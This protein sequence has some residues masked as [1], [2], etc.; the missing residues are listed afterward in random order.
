MSDTTTDTTKRIIKKYPNRRLYDTKTSSYVTLAYIK[1]LV[2]EAQDFRV[3][4]TK[5][6]ED[7]TRNVLLQIIL[8]EESVGIPIF[9]E[10]MLANIIRFYGQTMQSGMG[11][12]LERVIQTMI[13]VQNQIL[14]QPSLSQSPWAQWPNQ[15]W[16]QQSQAIFAQMQKQMLHL[17]DTTKK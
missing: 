17:F 16:M 7:L 11:A 6:N 13:Q 8:E 5:T 3:L 14:Q 2:I 15:S 10:I 12:Y 1:R 9:S 4:D